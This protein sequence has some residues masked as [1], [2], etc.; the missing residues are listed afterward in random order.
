MLGHARRE[1]FRW[2]GHLLSDFVVEDEQEQEFFHR[3]HIDKQY[4]RESH[5]LALLVKNFIYIIV[6]NKLA[7]FVL[8][9]VFHITKSASRVTLPTNLL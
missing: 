7:M 3:A 9:T 1:L 6:L 2:S 5:L 4:R 8:P